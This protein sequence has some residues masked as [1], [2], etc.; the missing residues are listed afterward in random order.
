VD[1]EAVGAL[2]LQFQIVPDA[3]T[4]VLPAVEEPALAGVSPVETKD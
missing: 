1:G 3:L 2:P 4:L